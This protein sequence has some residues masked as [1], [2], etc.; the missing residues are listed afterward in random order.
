[1]ATDLLS[2][3][4]LTP[5]GE[6]GADV[7]IGNSQ[8][9]GVPMGFGGPHAAFFATK[10]EFKRNI[11]GRI[12]G[13]SIDAQGN[14]CLRMAL[15]TR[16]QHIRREK[17]TSN[18]CT[19]QALL[20]NMAAMYAVYHGADGL[21]NI[22]GKRVAYAFWHKHSAAEL[23]ELRLCQQ[24]NTMNIILIRLNIQVDRCCKN[25]QTGRA[26]QQEINFSYFD[27]RDYIG[28][29]LD[30]TTMRAKRCT[31][32][33]ADSIRCC[34]ATIMIRQLIV[35]DAMMYTFRK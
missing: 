4:L 19:A 2:L 1:M 28:I 30:E 3:T 29:S 6:L 7:A 35:F 11:P 8:R 24:C 26:R 5:P 22:G 12:I 9:L 31:H 15:Q 16:E 27:N 25:S 20:A 13:V 23:A 32:H 18:I 21:K 14:R 17:A 34:I 33:T 10:D